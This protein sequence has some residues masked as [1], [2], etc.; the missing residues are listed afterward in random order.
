MNYYSRPSSSKVTQLCIIQICVTGQY[1]V[2]F[3][4]IK[5]LKSFNF[6][7]TWIFLFGLT[8]TTTLIEQL[9]LYLQR[10]VRYVTFA[11]LSSIFALAK[12]PNCSLTLQGISRKPFEIEK[13]QK[14]FC[15][16]QP[17]SNLKNLFTSLLI[18]LLKFIKIKCL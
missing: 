14:Q 10:F 2:I 5:K 13:K 18:K 7:K 11:E 12:C 1:I 9:V 4:Y 17:I 16:L 3:Y 15:N 8:S 6:I